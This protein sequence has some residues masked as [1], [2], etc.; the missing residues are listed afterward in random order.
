MLEI[1]DILVIELTFG[2]DMVMNDL[3]ELYIGE[4]EK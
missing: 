1:E 4:K 2:C 3:E